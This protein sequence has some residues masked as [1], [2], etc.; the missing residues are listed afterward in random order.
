MIFKKVYYQKKYH[1]KYKQPLTP[2][3]L[4]NIAA[5]GGQGIRSIEDYK[6]WILTSAAQ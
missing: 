1:T 4:K 5:A 2:D 3:Q 6:K